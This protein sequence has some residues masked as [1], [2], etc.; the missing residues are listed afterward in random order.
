MTT[1]ATEVTLLGKM[2]KIWPACKDKDGYGVVKIK[3]KMRK[4]HRI[5]LE[6]KIGRKLNKGEF[7]L[8]L[9]NIPACYEYTH[10]KIGT[11]AENNR[12]KRNMQ[13]TLADTHLKGWDELY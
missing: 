4:V 9:C 5:A 7:A 11:I 3:G 13:V 12:M 1:D 10:L 2:C 8:H 6:I